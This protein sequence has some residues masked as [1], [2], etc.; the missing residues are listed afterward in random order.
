MNLLWAASHP[1]RRTKLKGLQPKEAMK[2]RRSVGLLSVV[3][4]VSGSLA[5]GFGSG[6][7][8]EVLRP[9]VSREISPEVA[10]E[11]LWALVDGN[12]A[13]ALELYQRLRGQEGN[14]FFSPYSISLALAMV[15]AGAR[16][17]TAAE[18]A[19]ALHFSLP[20]ERLHPAFNALDLAIAEHAAA[21]GIEL[22]TANAF[23][24]QLGWPFLQSYIDLLAE[25]Y[26]A[27]LH[28]VDFH[29][30]PDACRVHINDWVSEKTQGKIEEL[31][32]PGSIT[33]LTRL[34]LTNAIYFK[35]AWKYRFD[36]WLT[37]EGA[38]HLLD[39]GTQT[40]SMMVVEE[41]W[42]GY[43][44]GCLDG[45]RYQAVELP[46]QGEE[47][48]MVILLP[49]L[50]GYWEF[51]RALDAERLEGILRELRS[52][53]LRLVM[54]KFSFS[55]GFSLR[56]TLSGLGM[57]R[58]F[59]PEPDFSEMDGTRDLWLNEVY[60][61]AFIKVD[62]WGTEAAAATGGVIVL[63]LPMEVHVDHPFMFL[64]RDRE[65]G[66]ILFLGRVLNPAG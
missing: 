35:G 34:V 49:D 32:P 63:A 4:L 11:E 1:L 48:S 19:E 5:A 50:A 44:E 7:Q 56:E 43:T 14:L 15:Y 57:P 61:E 31:L 40:A 55:S 3:L 25:N 24:G 8:E 12:T 47:L 9:S 52:W 60:H 6:C 21:G 58:A 39:G 37:H 13:F 64:I 28:L 59:S 30:T 23:W 27:E 36:P 42:L 53:E 29:D 54:P 65:T 46:Y 16:G 62:E 26:G 2:V 22:H 17:E 41:A 33:P 20:Q 45:V 51:E 66:A 10:E 18:M 38:F